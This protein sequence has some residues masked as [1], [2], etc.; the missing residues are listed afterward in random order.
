MRGK[1]WYAGYTIGWD[2]AKSYATGTKATRASIRRKLVRMAPSDNRLVQGIWQGWYDLVDQ[3]APA[4]LEGKAPRT[5]NPHK[6][7]KVLER[8]S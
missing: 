8:V 7:S 6:F 1:T 4:I 2:W 3:L 5:V